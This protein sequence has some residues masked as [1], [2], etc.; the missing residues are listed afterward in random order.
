[1]DFFNQNQNDPKL[2]RIDWI[3]NYICLGQL[4]RHFPLERRLLRLQLRRRP[5]PLGRSL[6]LGQGDN[7]LRKY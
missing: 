4:L 3:L 1:M 6:G 2:F 7:R 5:P